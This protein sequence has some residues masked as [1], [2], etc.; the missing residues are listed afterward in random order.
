MKKGSITI[1]VA[2][3]NEER[4][5]AKT[6]QEIKRAVLGIFSDYEILI[7]DDCSKDATGAISDSLAKRNPRIKV[8]HNKVNGGQGYNFREGIRLAS[9]DYVVMLPGDAAIP[10][11]S[12]R[13]LLSHA[14]KADLISTFLTNTDA[15]PFFRRV[16]SFGFVRMLSILFGCRLKYYNGIVLYKTEVVKKVKM[17]TNSFAFTAETV[18]RLLKQGYSYREIG[19]TSRENKGAI[20]SLFRFKNLFG[21]FKTLLR[22]FL[23]LRNN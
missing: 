6:I 8:I 14:G 23:E 4:F 11:K 22:L 20:T 15:R 9:K 18:I 13:L 2:A 16:L 5:I 21:V 1:I 10:E 17:T 7:F 19:I 3:Y 12:I